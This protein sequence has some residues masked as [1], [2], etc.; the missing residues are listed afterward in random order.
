M[1]EK[2]V[3]SEEVLRNALLLMNKETNSL[4]FI[5]KSLGVSKAVLRNT[6]EHHLGKL[7][8]NDWLEAYRIMRQK[9]LERCHD[10]TVWECQI[11]MYEHTNKFSKCPCCGSYCIQEKV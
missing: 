3:E 10:W 2:T 9:K 4:A 11:C 8:G 5:S 7:S 1:A 6:V